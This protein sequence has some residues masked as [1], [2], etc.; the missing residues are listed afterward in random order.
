M[1]NFLNSLFENINNQTITCKKIEGNTKVDIKIS[2][3]S[4]SKNISIK[5]G[6]G[7]SVHQESFYTFKEEF[8][9]PCHASKNVIGGL[10]KFVVKLKKK[11]EYKKYFKKNP[12]LKKEIQCFL[13]SKKVQILKRALKFGRSGGNY[14]DVVYYGTYK[15]GH[16][17]NIDDFIQRA[18]EST[19]KSCFHVGIATLQAYCRGCSTKTANEAD[20]LQL[21]INFQ[22]IGWSLIK[23][24]P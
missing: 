4:N 1:Q 3:G 21:K 22:K 9:I 18:P 23:F 8:L 16:W 11:N 10:E 15:K 12:D 24:E 19:N 6:K 20:D 7:C 13:D 5:V 2:I 17:M 14:I